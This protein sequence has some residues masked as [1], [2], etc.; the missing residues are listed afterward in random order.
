[1]SKERREGGREREGRREGKGPCL[2]STTSAPGKYFFTHSPALSSCLCTKSEGENTPF[3]TTLLMPNSAISL[4]TLS[5]CAS[6]TS[7]MIV[8]STSSPPSMQAEY[9]QMME[10]RSRGQS[11]P[12]GD[13]V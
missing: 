6:E 5:T 7:R 10:R 8:P 11:M 1:M 2:E 3:T 4:Q 13:V 12:G 9:L